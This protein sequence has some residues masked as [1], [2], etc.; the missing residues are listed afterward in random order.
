MK[1]I[2]IFLFSTLSLS[3]YSQD[4]LKI[5]DVFNFETG[6]VFIY[7]NSYLDAIGL[8]NITE[9]DTLINIRYSK[10]QDTVFY[11]FSQRR[12]DVRTTGTV[13]TTDS[14]SLRVDFYTNLDSLLWKYDPIIKSTTTPPSNISGMD[15]CGTQLRGYSV[16]II[17]GVEGL[18]KVYGK[19]LGQVQYAD[20]W[21]HS[22]TYKNLIYYHK[23]NFLCNNGKIVTGMKN[24]SSADEISIYPNPSS[25]YFTIKFTELKSEY[26]L[27]LYDIFGRK[28]IEYRNIN[29]STFE[30]T[31]HL[32]TGIYNLV[33]KTSDGRTFCKKILKI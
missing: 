24:V 21:P 12:H 20:V 18:T 29:S 15:G 30:C 1:K 9:W 10:Q 19:A 31:E 16:P 33:I 32:G 23:K 3:I 25:N 2:L 13:S 8:G 14:Y 6:D 27:S 11:T 17:M 26:S 5:R 7:Q 4:S 22:Y 28:I